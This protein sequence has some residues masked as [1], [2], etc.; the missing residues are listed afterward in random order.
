MNITSCVAFFD[1]KIKYKKNVQ[2]Y[3]ECFRQS[4][5]TITQINLY[6]DIALR[7]VCAEIF[8]IYFKFVMESRGR[9]F[10]GE[11]YAQRLQKLIYLH[12]FTDF[13]MKISLHSSEQIASW[14]SL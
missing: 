4:D 13:F 5:P 8:I 1:I 2:T 7:S 10:N 12:L 3:S 11:L 14:N 6:W 9:V